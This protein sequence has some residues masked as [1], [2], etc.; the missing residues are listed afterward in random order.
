MPTGTYKV[1]NNAPAGG[2]GKSIVIKIIKK[3]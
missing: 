1:S 3:K 2:S